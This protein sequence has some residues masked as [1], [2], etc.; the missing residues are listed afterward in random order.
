MVEHK[1]SELI[2]VG[3]E[4]GLVI[5]GQVSPTYHT[6]TKQSFEL[7]QGKSSFLTVPIVHLQ[8][9]FYCILLI[10]C[11]G[12]PAVPLTMSPL[13]DL[14]ICVQNNG[15]PT[16]SEVDVVVSDTSRRKQQNIA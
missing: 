10:I 11:I 9:V 15:S 7:S 6:I 12:V 2:L 13:D 8:T 16:T 14:H 1:V 4:S 5:A 3:Y